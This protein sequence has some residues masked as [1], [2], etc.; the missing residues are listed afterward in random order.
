MLYSIW[1]I[2]LGMLGAASL[3]MAKKPGTKVFFD[4]ISPYQSWFGLVSAGVG[5]WWLLQTLLNIM[6]YP[7][8]PLIIMLA[9]IAVMIG[10]G[11]IFGFGVLKTFINSSATKIKISLMIKMLIPYQVTL[12]IVGIVLGIVGLIG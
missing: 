6:Y 9:A 4:T 8:V 2:V 5:V 3:I 11:L 10:L 12:G 1:L 7:F